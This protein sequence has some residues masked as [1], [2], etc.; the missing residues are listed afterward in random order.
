[1]NVTY[2]SDLM[3]VLRIVHQ[4]GLK[5]RA[6]FDSSCMFQG[7]LLQFEW[8]CRSVGLTLYLLIWK[9]LLIELGLMIEPYTCTYSLLHNCI[10]IL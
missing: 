3:H 6:S 5:C 8:F 4:F 1:M 9:Y 2:L 10:S 7:Q